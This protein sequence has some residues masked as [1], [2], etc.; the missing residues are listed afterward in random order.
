MSGSVCRNGFCLVIHIVIYL[1]VISID[2][3]IGFLCLVVD[4]I[5]GSTRLAFNGFVCFIVLY[6]AVVLVATE[7]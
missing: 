4:G 3:L 7:T 5:I 2:A 6:L 1:S